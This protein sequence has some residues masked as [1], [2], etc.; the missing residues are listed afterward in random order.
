MEHGGFKHELEQTA[1]SCSGLLA[2]FEPFFFCF[3]FK[4]IKRKHQSEIINYAELGGCKAKR[5][6]RK[7]GGDG[8]LMNIGPLS[9]LDPDL[10]R[11]P[12]VFTIEKV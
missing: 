7:G 9:L 5:R 6:K 8:E 3:F 10:Q 11:F 4:P 12:L 2:G 1:N